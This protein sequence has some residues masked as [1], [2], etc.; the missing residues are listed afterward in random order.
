M[1]QIYKFPND[2]NKIWPGGQ[3]PPPPPPPARPH[4]ATPLQQL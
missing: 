2:R 3:L 1:L 4:V